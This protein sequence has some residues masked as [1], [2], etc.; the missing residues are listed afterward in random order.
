MSESA[1]LRA[2]GHLIDSGTLSKIFDRVIQASCTYEIVD[3]RIG[4]TNAEASVAELRVDAP[5]PQALRDLLENLVDLGCR[6]L[7][8]DEARAAPAPADGVVPDDFYSTTNHETWV[9]GATG[10]IRVEKQRMDS[11]IAFDGARAVCTKLRDVRRGQ[12]VVVGTAGIRVVPPDKERDRAHFGFMTNDVSSERRVE[13]AVDRVA[14]DVEA[15]HAA[16]RRVIAVAGPVVIHT[17]AVA[18]MEELIGRHAFDAILAGNAL[19]VHDIERAMFNTSLGIDAD[20]GEAVKDGHRNHMRAINAIRKAGGIA[21]AVR[22]GALTRGIMHRCVVEGV[23]FVLAGSLRDDGPLPEVVTDMNAAQ[24]AYARA[25]EGAGVVV[26]LSSM[27]HGIA[28][29]NM[30]PSGV[31]TVCVDIN[32]AVATKL[33]DRGSSQAIG[34]VTDVGAFL[35][36]LARRLTAER[37]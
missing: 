25:L 7:D 9:R 2:E 37:A 32:P 16:G 21:A 14:R 20:T 31:L 28:V 6:R 18:A 11:V 17:G 1:R 15:A 3:F 24:D 23:P 5:T 27:L 36:L 12:S 19:A 13:L 26:V 30:I 4:R 35:A 8:G 29:G 22:E 10:W 33:A 34:V